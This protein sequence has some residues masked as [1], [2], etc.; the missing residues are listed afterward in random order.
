MLQEFQHKH[1]MHKEGIDTLVLGQLLVR[2]IEAQ[3]AVS[4]MADYDV[5]AKLPF[6]Q[7]PALLNVQQVCSQAN[8]ELTVPSK[9]CDFVVAVDLNGASVDDVSIQFYIIPI[10]SLYRNTLAHRGEK[11]EFESIP[12][13]SAYRSKW[14]LVNDFLLN[15]QPQSAVA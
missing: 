14:C 10:H 15:V 9:A 8:S 7:Q 11:I 6:S 1:D 2:S 12:N 5:V 13:I 3:P 4:G